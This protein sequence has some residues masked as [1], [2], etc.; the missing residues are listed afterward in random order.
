MS[1]ATSP[2]MA[3]MHDYKDAVKKQDWARIESHLADDFVWEF[4]P[5]S[6]DA[7]SMSKDETLARLKTGRDI[8]APGTFEVSANQHKF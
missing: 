1:T 3:V 6:G 4:R 7:P 5:N 2:A 8:W